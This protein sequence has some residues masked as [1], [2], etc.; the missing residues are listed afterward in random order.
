M[1][2][3]T[4]FDSSHLQF[5]DIFRNLVII[6]CTNEKLGLGYIRADYAWT[7]VSSLED[8]LAEYLAPQLI[9]DICKVG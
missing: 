1:G 6:P 3:A 7:A 9:V 2:L 4:A 5:F 8:N